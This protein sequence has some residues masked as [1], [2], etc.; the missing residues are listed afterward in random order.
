MAIKIPAKNIYG[1]IDHQKLKKNKITQI[2]AEVYEPKTK[3]N[4]ISFQS[5]AFFDYDDE[6]KIYTFKTGISKIN[7]FETKA[8]SATATSTAKPYVLLVKIPLIEI[9]VSTTI[10]DIEQNIYD[11][12][13]FNLSANRQTTEFK[14]GFLP[15]PNPT[16][17]SFEVISNSVQ[18]ETEVVRIID[19]SMGEDGFPV[20]SNQEFD[21]SGNRNWYGNQLKLRVYGTGSIGG[22]WK[23]YFFVGIYCGFSSYKEDGTLDAQR[24]I[25]TNATVEILINNAVNFEEKTLTF[26]K[27]NDISGNTFQIEN[28]H[29]LQS[30]TMAQT[31][32]NNIF[33]EWGQGKETITLSCAIDDYYE[34][35]GDLA[36]NVNYAETENVFPFD[37]VAQANSYIM[38]YSPENQMFYTT[39]TV[40]ATDKKLA[41]YR[42]CDTYIYLVAGKYKISFEKN[43]V[44]DFA[45]VGLLGD[46]D[47]GEGDYLYK[48]S[49]DSVWDSTFFV[50]EGVAPIGVL[51]NL[52]KGDSVKI[53]LYKEEPTTK[54]YIFKELPMT[55]R[56]LDRV[57]PYVKDTS[58]AE[59]PISLDEDGFR[60]EFWVRGIEFDTKTLLQKLYLQEF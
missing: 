23:D 46:D 13:S 17:V 12:L 26:Q 60:K 54:G 44:S 45:Q 1:E 49:E 24:Q 35:N 38:L 37:E 22:D 29:Y 53:K 7:G 47:Y 57:V 3:T 59:V 8:I 34:E 51:L 28:C 41:A 18:S 58:G 50:K 5:G 6:S 27:E 4:S 40:Y 25:A 20:V 9:A 56:N 30:E 52:G 42:E 32:A 39:D 19:Y 10:G 43:I 36:I 21:P 2:S 16:P 11:S 15:T 31:S 55:F 14:E 33:A 48:T